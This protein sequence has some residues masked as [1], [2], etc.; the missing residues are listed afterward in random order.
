[1]FLVERKI[2][3]QDAARP[4]ARRAD[5]QRADEPFQVLGEFWT[6]LAARTFRE[7]R[8]FVRIRVVDRGLRSDV[9]GVAVPGDALDISSRGR[10]GEDVE[11]LLRVIPVV[12]PVPDQ[13]A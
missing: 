12:I 11:R 2:P 10:V 5:D 1:M 4:V 6:P 9:A 7:V 8:V 13:R 3:E